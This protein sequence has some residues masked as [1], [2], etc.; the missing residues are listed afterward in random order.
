MGKWTNSVFEALK[1]CGGQAAYEELYQE[2]ENLC[3]KKGYDL[4]IFNDYK[5]KPNWKQLLEESFNNILAIKAF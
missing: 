2:F 4:S 5:G 1:N 3:K